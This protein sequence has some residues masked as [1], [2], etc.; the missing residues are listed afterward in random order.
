MGQCKK[1]VYTFSALAMELRLLC[2]KSSRMSRPTLLFV[3]KHTHTHT[4]IYIYIW[5]IYKFMFY[6][7]N[8]SLQRLPFLLFQAVYFTAT[9]PYLVLFALFIRGV[10][11]PGAWEGIKYYLKPDF[12]KMRNPAVSSVISKRSDWKNITRVDV[13]DSVGGHQR[14]QRLIGL[15]TKRLTLKNLHVTS[16]SLQKWE[17]PM[18]W[19]NRNR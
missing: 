7:N 15:A 3:T 2:T 13:D 11:L 19:L 17:L 16:H 18:I 9:F 10:S 14:S 4:Y 12:I 1:D 5:Y 6:S 8:S